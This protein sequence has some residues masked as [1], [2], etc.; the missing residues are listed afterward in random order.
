AQR[1]RFQHL[2]VDEFQDVNP[3]QFRLLGAWL[4]DSA[5]VTVV[6]DAGQAIYGWNGAAASY[7]TEFETHFP[8][9]A[10]RSLRHNYRSSPQLVS[11]A[12]AVRDGEAPRT[13]RGDGP[14][15]QIVEF[16]DA[17]AEEAGIVA[18]ARACRDR[19]TPYRQQAILVRTRALARRLATA[20]AEAGVAVSAEGIDAGTPVMAFLRGLPPATPLGS[21][22]VDVALHLSLAGSATALRRA[23][24]RVAETPAGPI[25]GL[26]G[27]RDGDTVGTDVEAIDAEADPLDD[28]DDPD[29]ATPPDGASF[30]D[31]GAAHGEPHPRRGAAPVP[32]RRDRSAHGEAMR[33]VLALADDHLAVDADATVGRFLAAFDADR[34][35]AAPTGVTV[36]TFHAAK[37]REWRA[38]HVA[39]VEDGYV[40][41]A[42]A[43]GEALAEERRLLYVALTRA[44][45]Q[46]TCSWTRVRRFGDVDTIRAASPWLDAVGTAASQAAAALAPVPPPTDLR[47]PLARPETAETRL[48]QWRDRHAR[49]V[50]VP[51]AAV[52]PD[53][54]IAA[55]AAASPRDEAGLAAV[56]GVGPL[57]AARLGPYV[58][59]ALHGG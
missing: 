4:G 15:P 26:V 36:S 28:P 35:G 1:W 8:G 6:G 51:A 7:L 10:I 43:R 52:L 58:L 19:G 30:D 13:A 16:G 41:L 25:H 34:A 53:D 45:E 29:D 17:E 22:L 3:L 5:D 48:R 37:G 59:A 18:W 47:S 12:A 44:V 24:E 38:V 32:D 21:A 11:V 42:G 39:G 50:S 49:A 20:L 14:V 31:P 54:V 57:R 40:P 23:G 2:F 33:A 56:P 46:L 9:A 55:V 27:A